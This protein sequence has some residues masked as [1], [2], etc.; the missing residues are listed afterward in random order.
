MSIDMKIIPV[1]ADGDCLYHAFIKGLGIDSLTPLFLRDFVANRILNDKD[2]YDDLIREWMDFKVVSSVDTI[3]PE[4]AAN[5]IRNSKEWATST[6]I[7][8]L[9]IAFNVRIIVFQKINGQFYSEIFPSEWK[10]TC[11]KKKLKKQK[12]QHKDIYL[13]RRGYHFELLVPIVT[14]NSNGNVISGNHKENHHTS[15]P[16]TFGQRGGGIDPQDPGD[17]GD[18]MLT[19]TLGI[20]GIVL[21]FFT[22]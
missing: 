3:T 19:V 13:Y 20:I 18:P 15:Q 9:S 1:P 21:F 11:P 16:F 14:N 12:Q 7:H 8:I 2:L 6:V 22:F 5:H 10:E 4:I 17:P